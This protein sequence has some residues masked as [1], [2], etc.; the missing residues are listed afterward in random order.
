MHNQ[1]KESE[2]K[3]LSSLKQ[4]HPTSVQL[5]LQKYKIVPSNFGLDCRENILV[6]LQ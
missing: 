6:H 1:G 3:I 4:K 5:H 2:H